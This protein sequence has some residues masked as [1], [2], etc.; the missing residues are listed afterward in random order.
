MTRFPRGELEGAGGQ[1]DHTHRDGNG[2]RQHRLL[3]LD[4]NQ[5]GAQRKGGHSEP[6][7]E[8]K[9]P[10]PTSAVSR[11]SRVSAVLPAAWW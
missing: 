2:T 11:P 5:R 10:K 1:D 3:H 4:R 9:Y 8:E 7:P 6:G